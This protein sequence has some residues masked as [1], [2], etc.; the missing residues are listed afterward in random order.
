VGPASQDNALAELKAKM[1]LGP[2]PEAKAAL[3]AASTDPLAELEGAKPS[4]VPAPT[5][6]K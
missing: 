6:N 5:R 4:V 2:M 3:P 1:G